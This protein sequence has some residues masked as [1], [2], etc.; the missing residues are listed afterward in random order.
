[1]SLF[2]SSVRPPA[3]YSDEA[4]A[5][6]LAAL[7]GEIDPD[8]AFRRRLRGVVVNQ[9]VVARERGG[10]AV[11]ADRFSPARTMGRLG[12][13]VLYASF[14]LGVSVTGVM[15]ASDVAV[16]GDV[17]YPLKRAI[18]DARMEV[19]PEQFHAALESY[20][21]SERLG[22]LATL[23]ERGDD[24]HVAELAI[25]ITTEYHVVP[26]SADGGGGSAAGATLASLID[27]LPE[28][29]Q[30]AVTAALDAA[31]NRGGSSASSGGSGSE[32]GAGSGNGN[33]GNGNAN[34]SNNGNGNANG[35]DNGSGSGNG[36]GANNGNGNGNGNGANNGNANGSGAGNG[37][38]GS[39]RGSGSS[40]STSPDPATEP[41]ADEADASPIQSATPSPTPKAKKSPQP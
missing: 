17:L 24:A 39:G 1:M 20:E 22:E 15:A 28:Q 25:E 23:V 32:A 37:G 9:F 41:S 18:E 38:Q 19:L 33:T 27:Q 21:V 40:P 7:R 12:R 4:V 3:I 6:Y 36:S 8:P 29:A 10:R 35:A 5:R 11:V 2:R 30:D 13:A 34:G 14:A 26:A 31:A 16:P